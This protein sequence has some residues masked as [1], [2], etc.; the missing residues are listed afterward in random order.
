[1][2]VYNQIQAAFTVGMKESVGVDA[3]FKCSIDKGIDKAVRK[4]S[5]HLAAIK[6]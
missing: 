2:G 3:P 5:I 1:M 4:Y 6:I